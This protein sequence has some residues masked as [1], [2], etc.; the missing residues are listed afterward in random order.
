[1]P[2]MTNNGRDCSAAFSGRSMTPCEMVLWAKTGRTQTRT[3]RR[4]VLSAHIRLAVVAAK[5][6]VVHHA[7]GAF[8]RLAT[9]SNPLVRVGTQITDRA[10]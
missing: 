4:R 10:S 2:V 8:W 5:I 1:M 7:G 9:A 6:A 3:V